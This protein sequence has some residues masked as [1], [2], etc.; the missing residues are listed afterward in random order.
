MANRGTRP[1][2][3]T[4]VGAWIAANYS[5]PS[6]IIAVIG[7][8]SSAIGF[9][10]AIG[11]PEG[12]SPLSWLMFAGPALTG[13]FPTLELTWDREHDLS[14]PKVIRRW[15]LFPL[16]GAA[17]A[18]IAMGITELVARWTGVLAAAQAAD[19]WHYWFPADGPAAPSVLFG[20][21]G[22][23]A[24]V[25]LAL[26]FY[27]VVLWPLQILLRP[28]QAIRENRMDIAPQ[29]FRRNRAALA[30]RPL[31]VLNA[32]LIGVAI[33]LELGWWLVVAS[34]LPQVAM[35]VAAVRLQRLDPARRRAAAKETQQRQVGVGLFDQPAVDRAQVGR[36]FIELEE[37]GLQDLVLLQPE[38]AGGDQSTGQV[39]LDP[40]PEAGPVE[41]VPDVGHLQPGLLPDLALQRRLEGLAALDVPRRRT[42]GTPGPEPMPQQQGPAVRVEDGA[43]HADHE[44][45][46]PE[47]EHP[48]LG[49][50]AQ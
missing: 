19:K 27:V 25:L 33:V 15:M 48:P 9:V 11:D 30:L 50:A 23:V 24:G 14:M 35:T 8:L 12:E 5:V 32:V 38:R 20:L 13:A 31:L 10:T 3:T 26:A 36:E 17:G 47:P 37:A 22:Y 28:R 18:V 4:S 41:A 29:H 43:G 21:L 42:P 45:R 6:L 46:V 7:V 40:E 34:I 44:G 16:F 39:D 1:S 49:L 2:R